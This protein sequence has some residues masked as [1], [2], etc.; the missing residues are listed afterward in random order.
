MQVLLR[1]W[2]VLT[3]SGLH[4][5]IVTSD[6]PNRNDFLLGDWGYRTENT[7]KTD[8]QANDISTFY[9]RLKATINSKSQCQNWALWHHHGTT[10]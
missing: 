7:G 5:A 3:H 8:F 10:I 2:V 6:R 4:V 9:V 1:L